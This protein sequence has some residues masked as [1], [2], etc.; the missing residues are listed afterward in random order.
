MNPA[1]P[2]AAAVGYAER[3]WQVFPC[4]TT[5]PG[6]CSC[7]QADAC[8]SPGKHP[9]TRHGLNDATVDPRQ[10]ERWF[11]A[12]A[13]IGIRTGAESGL[14]VVDIDPRHGGDATWRRLTD[15]HGPVPTYTVRTGGG[16][17]HLYLQ[18]PGRPVRNSA[19]MLGPGVDI[20]GDGGYVLAPPSTHAC[21]GRYELADE[22][23]PAAAPGWLLDALRPPAVPVTR[24]DWMHD[25]GTRGVD[26]WIDEL[27]RAPHGARNDTLNRVAF[28]LGRHAAEAGGDDLALRERLVHEA[29]GI[30]LGER[31]ARRT[32]DS[33]FRAGLRRSLG[34][35]I[36]L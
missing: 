21:G 26:R 32:T 30:G 12:P 34:A 16:G 18:H 5:H 6:G 24:R 4:H 7:A 23:P 31:E 36:E 25:R 14:V 13:N 1:D 19:G 22:R 10:L 15:R 28:I 8:A 29:V 27:R 3:G 2:A 17:T 20:R 33:G 35:G 11:A 9:R